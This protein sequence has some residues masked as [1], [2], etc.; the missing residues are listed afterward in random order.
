MAPPIC[1]QCTVEQM[2]HLFITL[3]VMQVQIPSKIGIG[4]VLQFNDYFLDEVYSGRDFYIGFVYIIILHILHSVRVIN[5]CMTSLGEDSSIMQHSLP[6]A[7]CRSV[8]KPLE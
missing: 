6:R 5:K 4:T 8:L 2:I 3:G 1:G 7:A